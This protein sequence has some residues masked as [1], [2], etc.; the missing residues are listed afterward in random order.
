MCEVLSNKADYALLDKLRGDLDKGVKRAELD[1]LLT[2]LK[3]E[4][5]I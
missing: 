2:R 4:T 5:E 3:Q 1:S